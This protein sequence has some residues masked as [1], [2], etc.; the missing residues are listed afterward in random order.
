MKRKN[1]SEIPPGGNLP[2]P[3]PKSERPGKRNETVNWPQGRT[4]LHQ[5]VHQPGAL[6][7]CKTSSAVARST[8]IR[9]SP[10]G[11]RQSTASRGHRQHFAELGAACGA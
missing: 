7:K 9:M 11:L 1:K 6:V 3:G 10:R 8:P 2:A 5:P 4:P